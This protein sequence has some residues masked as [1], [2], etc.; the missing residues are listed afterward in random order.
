M[1]DFDLAVGILVLDS[2][3]RIVEASSAF[4]RSFE[5]TETAI[6]GVQ[7]DEFIARR[8]RRGLR[9]FSRTLAS[10]EP[11]DMLLAFDFGAEDVLTRIRLMHVDGRHLALVERI[12][13]D[14]NLL[15]ELYRD[16]RRWQ[17]VIKKSVEGVVILDSQGRILD[18]NDR[19]FEIMG[20]RSKAGILLSEEALQG[21][22]F[23]A[24]S[25][26]LSGFEE[27]R[28]HLHAEATR[29]TRYRATIV[30][31][32]RW[33]E[34]A[35]TSLILP[36]HGFIGSS[37][38]LRDITEERQT[39]ILLRQKESAEAA[40]VAKSRFLANMS[41]ELRTPLNAIIGYSEM[42][43]EEAEHH[44]DLETADDLRKI[45]HSGSYL[46]QLIN[47]ILDL[48]KIEAGK[49]ELWCER[50]SISSMLEDVL[51]TAMPLVA[52]NGNQLEVHGARDLGQMT[53]DLL[54]IRQVLLNLLSNAGK[55]TKDGTITLTLQRIENSPC[56]MLEIEIADTG[57]GIP[58][59]KL[60]RIFEEFAQADATTSRAYG[61]TGLG[62]A[63][64][65]R[66]CRI[67]GGELRV[68]S[69]PGVG[70][71]FTV[72]LPTSPPENTNSEVAETSEQ[73]EAANDRV[74]ARGI[75]TPEQAPAKA[76]PQ[77]RAQQAAGS[78]VL[79]IDDDPAVLDMMIRFLSREGWSVVAASS[80]VHA[81]TLARSLQPSAITLDVLMPEAEG[82]GILAAIKADPEIA[83]IPVIMMSIVDDQ[84][85]GLRLGATDYL[86]KPID[87]GHLLRVLNRQRSNAPEPSVLIIDDDASARAL[88][89]THLARS[90][91]RVSEACDGDDGLDQIDHER[92]DLVLLDLIMPRC[93]GFR[94]LHRLRASPELCDIP[95]VVLTA[96]DL[97]SE[98][99]SF[100]SSEAQ[101]ILG[102]TVTT[103]QAV[104][105]G[106]RQQ[107][108]ELT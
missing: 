97:T 22:D 80:P 101:E 69:T 20:F 19:F 32:D 105:D 55:F 89:R 2:E 3:L 5:T 108:G 10:G 81:L 46:L 37:I 59:A 41:H 14:G 26:D 24:L 38:V 90:G 71:I 39:E 25:A 106:L 91:W 48:S 70:S 18:H 40:N 54:K 107:L 65:Q 68:R 77:T 96:K 47:N 104:L 21:A 33:I 72:H 75:E 57:I 88:V 17:Q 29:H 86:L 50:F 85:R 60:C 34:I 64:S 16:R 6:L 8:D 15:F 61:G 84:S 103:R 11:V 35:T 102:K 63:L 98:E 62:L 31:E 49:M 66:F 56:D 99:R 53:S 42:I 93:D 30:H 83:E 43:L 52:K 45:L 78:T 100:L 74:P 94:F 1:I 12:D 92:P 79:V 28:T 13:G 67:L 82:W 7:L 9:E 95:V 23:L 76:S 58:E 44:G 36:V 51:A 4:C 27:L 73:H 87:R